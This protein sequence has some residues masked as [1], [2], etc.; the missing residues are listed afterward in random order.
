MEKR[1]CTHKNYEVIYDVGDLGYF[2]ECKDCGKQF[3][4]MAT[5]ENAFRAFK[6]ENHE[7]ISGL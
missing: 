3:D 7:S 5:P 1:K 6:G 4:T 2:V